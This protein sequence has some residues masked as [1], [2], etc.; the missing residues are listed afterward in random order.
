MLCRGVGG[1]LCRP[2]SKAFFGE[3]VVESGH[4][5]PVECPVATEGGGEHR[6]RVRAAEAHEA[7]GEGGR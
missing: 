6:G 2:G 7:V 5:R 4:H 3:D 1:A